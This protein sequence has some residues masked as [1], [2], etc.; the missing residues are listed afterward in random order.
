M[1]YLWTRGPICTMSYDLPLDYLKFIVGLT[2][3]SDLQH[4]MLFPMNITS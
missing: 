1:V 2:Y 3:D 4:A